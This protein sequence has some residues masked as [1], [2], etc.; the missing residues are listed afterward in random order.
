MIDACKTSSIVHFFNNKSSGTR[1]VDHTGGSFDETEC[2][3]QPTAKV[4]L[5]FVGAFC[6]KYVDYGSSPNCFL[7]LRMA[8]S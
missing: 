5:L 7:K 1:T 4:A 6:M 2:Q 3:K 8:C